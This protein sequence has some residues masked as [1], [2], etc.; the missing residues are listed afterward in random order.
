MGGSNSLLAEFGFKSEPSQ[1]GGK[2]N[3]FGALYWIDKS[4]QP[5]LSIDEKTTVY[6]T[7]GYLMV[8]HPEMGTLLIRNS[9]LLFG[10]DLLKQPAYYSERPLSLE[11]VSQL[12]SEKDLEQQAFKRIMDPAL[13]SK[14]R[15]S[16]GFAKLLGALEDVKK[17]YGDWKLNPEQFDPEDETRFIGDTGPGMQALYQKLSDM[18]ADNLMGLSEKPL[19]RLALMARNLPPNKGYEW[20]DAGGLMQDSLEVTETVLNEIRD[21]LNGSW[22]QEKYPQSQWHPFIQAAVDHQ[23]E[24]VLVDG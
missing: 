17:Q 13:Y 10:R 3:P 20:H 23:A 8:T 12:A 7:R 15:F 1:A 24:L 19:P 21:R 14:E 11:Q 18:A 16:K 5:A 22:S 4:R 2:Q 9:S 6:F